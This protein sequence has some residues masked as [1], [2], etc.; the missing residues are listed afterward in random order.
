[1]PVR[2]LA[3]ENDLEITTEDGRDILLEDSKQAVNPFASYVFH[4]KANA[5][6]PVVFHTLSTPKSAEDKQ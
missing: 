5:T 4:P 2:K 1:M 3:T 6:T